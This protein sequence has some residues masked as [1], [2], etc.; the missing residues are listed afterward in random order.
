MSLMCG[1]Y[2]LSETPARLGARYRVDVGSLEFAPEADVR[3]TSVNPVILLRGGRRVVELMRWGLVPSWATE[4]KHFVGNF[5]ARSEQAPE[6]PMFREPFR[7]RRC[8]VPASAFYEWTHVP[9]QRRK[10]KYRITRSDGD[11]VALAGVWD[12]WRRGDETIRSY[13]ILTTEPNAM[14]AELHER[15]PVILGEEEWDEWLSPETAPDTVRAMCMPCP[16]EWLIAAPA[17]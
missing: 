16:S 14:M 6:R 3:P 15:M 13:T 17:A 9:G 4:P 12:Y 5:N 1:R 10:I 8:L 11:L 7:R 2:D